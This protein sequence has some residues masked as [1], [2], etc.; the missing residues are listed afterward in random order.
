M[1]TVS[2]DVCMRA[3]APCGDVYPFQ[4][5]P[6]QVGVTCFHAC[7]NDSDDDSFAL[8]L[9]PDC[10]GSIQNPLHVP[11]VVSRRSRGRDEEQG[12]VPAKATAPVAD[13]TPLACIFLPLLQPQR[14]GSTS[15]CGND[16]LG[17]HFTSGTDPGPELPASPSLKGTREWLGPHT[18]VASAH[19]HSGHWIAAHCP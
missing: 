11:D 4:D 17:D 1:D 2:V 6:C 5:L 8:R 3:R 9:Q 13:R 18:S 7:V 12:K 16:P 15:L 10:L 14:R 19:R